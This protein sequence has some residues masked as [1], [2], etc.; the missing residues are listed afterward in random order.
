MGLEVNLPQATALSWATDL[1][2]HITGLMKVCVSSQVSVPQ[3]T[4]SPPTGPEIPD[5]VDVGLC[6][7][8]WSLAEKG[9]PASSLSVEMLA[10]WREE[11]MNPSAFYSL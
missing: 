9:I 3:E 1:A 11:S 4:H 6:F 2:L 5:V 8:P 10:G 7:Q